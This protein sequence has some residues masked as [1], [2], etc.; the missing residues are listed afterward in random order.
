MSILNKEEKQ[1]DNTPRKERPTGRFLALKIAITT[2]LCSIAAT[3]TYTKTVSDSGNPPLRV[4][5]VEVIVINGKGDTLSHVNRVDT[6]PQRR[7]LGKSQK[8]S[9]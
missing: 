6:L 8:E 5:E 9:K 3:L 7:T 4:R 1:G 2:A